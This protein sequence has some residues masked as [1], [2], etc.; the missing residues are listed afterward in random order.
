MNTLV[1]AHSE[2]LSSARRN[3]HPSSRMMLVDLENVLLRGRSQSEKA[4]TQHDLL[5]NGGVVETVIRAVF[6]RAWV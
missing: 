6:A 4:A 1:H 3:E 5:K 2:T